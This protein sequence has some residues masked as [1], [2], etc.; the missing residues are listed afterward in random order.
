[1]NYD[2]VKP[3]FA[4]DMAFAEPEEEENAGPYDNDDEDDYP[5]FNFATAGDF[6]CGDEAKR[7]VNNIKAK[8]PELVILTG[9]LSYQKYGSLLVRY[10]SSFRYP[11]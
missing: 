2:I 5:D 10:G 7:T 11:R 9:D 8:N 6:G 4:Q 3:A 1:M